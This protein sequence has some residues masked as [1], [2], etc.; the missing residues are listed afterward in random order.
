MLQYQLLR[1]NTIVHRECLSNN[2]VCAIDR[3]RFRAAKHRWMKRRDPLCII[4][5]DLEFDLRGSREH[6]KAKAKARSF[7]TWAVV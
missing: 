7:G 3:S 5:I 6:V 1:L 4:N 2:Y